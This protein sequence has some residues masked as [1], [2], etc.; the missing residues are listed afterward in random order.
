MLPVI[1]TFFCIL[2]CL[3]PI[4]IFLALSVMNYKDPVPQQVTQAITSSESQV[5]AH[6]LKKR[7]YDLAALGAD[8]N[9][10]VSTSPENWCERSA[11]ISSNVFTITYD[12]SRVQRFLDRPLIYAM[13]YSVSTLRCDNWKRSP[14]G[15]FSCV[16]KCV[17]KKLGMCL[18]DIL[19][20]STVK[21]TN[22]CILAIVAGFVKH[23]EQILIWF[24]DIFV[25]VPALS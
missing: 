12:L 2:T 15:Y 1:L 6:L 5:E 4:D 22:W 7:S 9:K 11:E 19:F 18:F 17:R 10:S 13:V 3:V 21:V 16:Y 23:T 24:T 20:T 8:S 25:H 14:W